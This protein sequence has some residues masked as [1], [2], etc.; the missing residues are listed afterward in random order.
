MPLLKIFTS[1]DPL[2]TAART[3]LLRRASRML[4]QELGKPEDYVMT[5]LLPQ[6]AMTFGGT[7]A[8]SAYAE[9]KNIGTFTPELT[10]RLS[11]ELCALLSSALSVPQDRIYLEFKNAEAH[12]WGFDGATF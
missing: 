4:A 12:L 3:D 5:C 10:Q 7:E 11:R 1:V 2:P 9:L 6:T 8:P